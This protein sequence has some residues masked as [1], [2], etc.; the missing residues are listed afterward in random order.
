MGLSRSLRI[1]CLM[2]LKMLEVVAILFCLIGILLMFYGL[3]QAFLVDN[4]FAGLPFSIMGLP[5]FIV[6]LEVF[7]ARKGW[8]AK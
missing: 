1:V 4:P 8:Y 5:F 6:G 7:V 3:C 2:K